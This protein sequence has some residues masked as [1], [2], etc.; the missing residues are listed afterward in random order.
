MKVGVQFEGY[1]QE[2]VRLQN[3]VSQDRKSMT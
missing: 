3:I 1:I 2:I